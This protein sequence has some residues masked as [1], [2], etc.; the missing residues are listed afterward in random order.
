[1]NR[2]YVNITAYI[3]K[4]LDEKLRK[5]AE[6]KKVPITEI[7]RQILPL[8]LEKLETEKKEEKKVTDLS[9]ALEEKKESP[10]ASLIVEKKQRRKLSEE[11]RRQ[12]AEKAL[13]LRRKG[14][15]YE[16]IAKELGRSISTVWNAINSYLEEMEKT[17]KKTAPLFCPVL[18]NPCLEEACGLYDPLDKECSILGIN[19]TLKEIVRTRV[20]R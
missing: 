15:T 1:M 11:E 17:G 10:L 2:K 12:L 4:E 3:P 5:L 8:A 7:V 19:N 6:E 13:E 20:I 14:W 16:K 18:D 9:S